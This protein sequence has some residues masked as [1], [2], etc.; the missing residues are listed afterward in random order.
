VR[1]QP[2]DLS[3]P[4]LQLLGLTYDVIQSLEGSM[5][6]RRRP[7][8]LLVV[9][10]RWPLCQRLAIK[11]FFHAATIYQLR[12]ATSAPVSAGIRFFDHPSARIIARSVLEIYLTMFEVFFEPDTD[13][14]LEFRFAQWQLS[15]LV[16]RTD[17]FR[18]M[19][20]EDQKYQSEAARLQE[21]IE[22]MCDRIQRTEAFSS[23]TLKQQHRALEGKR[24][25][26]RSR[27]EMLEACGLGVQTF[28][29]L[30]GA[31]SSDVHSDELSLASIVDADSQGDQVSHVEATMSAIAMLMARMIL[32]YEETFSEAKRLCNARSD[33]FSLAQIWAEAAG[34]LP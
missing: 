24:M 6:E 34:E 4:Y 30:Y 32:D 16:R 23:L 10:A 17:L 5:R 20:P 19:A 12:Q 25:P 33:G 14:L 26:P 15:S 9:D 27:R 18:R 7:S 29:L 1:A 28:G 21:R 22:E 11:M 13:D 3:R 31:W 2:I 8:G